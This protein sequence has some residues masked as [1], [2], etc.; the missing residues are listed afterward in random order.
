M[1]KL[2]LLLWLLLMS[3]ISSQAQELASCGQRP[4]SLSLP[5]VRF[6]VGCL[7]E[8]IHDQSGGELGFTALATRWPM[9]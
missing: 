9:R 3:V 6:G 7:E 1:R 2:I 8:V 4:T 5:I